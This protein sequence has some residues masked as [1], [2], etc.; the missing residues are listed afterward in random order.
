MHLIADSGSTKCDWIIIDEK[1]EIHESKTIGLNPF[2]HSTQFI[3][4]RILENPLLIQNKDKILKVSY[5]GAGCSSV[6]RNAIVEDGLKMVF[7]HAKSILVAEDMLAAAMAT[8]KNKPGIVCILGTG[9]NSCYYDLTQIH[10]KVPALGYVIGDEG[11]GAHLGKQL[12]AA[13]LYNQLPEEV[14]AYFKQ[15]EL[16]KDQLL[17]KVYKESHANVFLASLV[18]M[19]SPVGKHPFIQ[20]IINRSLEEFARIHIQCFPNYQDIPV[21]FVGSIAYYYQENIKAIGEKMGFQVGK[22]IKQPIKALA[23]ESA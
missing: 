9:S 6:A 4:D 14:E 1:G 10:Q 20:N 22:I 19:I 18:K 11:S 2:F 8:C 5:Y 17:S 3:V 12:L 13:Y 21:H 15:Q 7:T 16:S 23:L